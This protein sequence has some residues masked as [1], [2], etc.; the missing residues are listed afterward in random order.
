M[1]KRLFS[2]TL[3]I[4]CTGLV[5]FFIASVFITYTN[6][7]HFAKEA[8]IETA[9]IYADLF[10]ESTDLEAFVR[11][12]NRTRITV[13]S[14]DGRVLADTRPLDVSEL[15]NH[16]SRPEIKAAN[17]GTPSAFVRYSD[18]LHMEL[19]YYAVKVPSGD[20]FVFI[21]A[22]IPVAQVGG[23][24]WRSV[25]LLI[26]VLILVIVI[27]FFFARGMAGR[28][29]IPLDSVYQKLKSLAKGEVSKSPI[30]Q[31]YEEINRITL[32]IDDISGLLQQNIDNLRGEKLKLDY[33]L[34]NIGD[35]LI[36][37]DKDGTVS[38][39]NTGVLR[40]FGSSEDVIGKKLNYLT[41]EKALI[42]AIEDCG[43]RGQSALFEITIDG[44]IFLVTVKRL[45][46]TEL[47]MAVLSNVTENRE[48]AKRREEFFA[49]ASHEL[50]TPLTAIKGLNELTMINSKDESITKYLSGIARETDRMLSLIGDMLKLSELENS[51]GLNPVPVMLRRTVDDVKE[52]LSSL[53][54]DR[55]ILFEADGDGEVMAEPGHIYELLKNLIENAVRYNNNGGSIKVVVTRV[56]KNHMLTVSDTGIGIS[57]AEQTR[58][59]ER[60]YRVEKSRS[61]QGGGT[62][63]GL[64]IV[65]HICT[66]YDWKLSLKSKPGIGTEI[67][68]LF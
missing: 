4:V 15:A 31:S 44:S 39:A 27:S 60:F 13:I 34:N 23:Y 40:I 3:L 42:Q 10:S 56:N 49:N 22:A 18:T 30:T 43:T 53:M 50:K 29:I 52:T 21:R 1:K 54:A 68:V 59:F 26:L 51:K 48:N 64:S 36:A 25:P 65:K 58:I 47:T 61:Q 8:V 5:C 6:N 45:P 66:L 2:Y 14:S 24:L 17:D 35:G 7:I 28:V 11:A 16:L 38:L 12:G 67:T 33:I 57:S 20:S 62:G 37:V 32:E 9:R 19:I 46:D 63:L 41:Y 55:A